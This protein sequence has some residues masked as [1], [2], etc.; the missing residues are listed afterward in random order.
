MRP[1]EILSSEHRVIEQVL[2]CLERIAARAELQG[3]VDLASARDAVRFVRTFADRCHHGK[4]EDHLFTRLA[5]RGLPADVGPV[6]VMLAE[7]EQGRAEIA[8]VDEAI[9][10]SA[11]GDADA[12]RRFAAHSRAYVELLREHI[13]KEDHVLFPLAESV[14]RDDDREAVL[15]GFAEVESHGPT[16]HD[17]EEMLAVAERLAERYAVPR[18]AERAPGVFR[19]C[20]HGHDVG[21]GAQ[22]SCA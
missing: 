18:A 1:T 12:P 19:G 22:R 8:A 17:H 7:H 11:A 6:A 15:A 16:A 14:L 5:R 21:G 2:D 9:D 20:C 13:A 4:E 3:E 10:A